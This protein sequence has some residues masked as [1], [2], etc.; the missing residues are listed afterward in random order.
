M[1]YRYKYGNDV[2]FVHV[3]DDIYMQ[4]TVTIRGDIRHAG[5]AG[6]E[7]VICE[8]ENGK[9]FMCHESKIYLDDWIRTSMKE[10]KERIERKELVTSADLCQAILS[11]G[12]D[13]V[14]FIV[15]LNTVCGLGFFLNG[16]KFKN[17]VCKIEERDN[18]EVKENYKLTVVPVKPDETVASSRDFYTDDMLSLIKSGH[19]QI[20]A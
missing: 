10:L 7:S 11:D 15:P 9:F 20:V 17:T 4:P 8:D 14:R 3:W 13:N 5:Y 1:V 2:I 6:Y 16:D 12:V 18:R 19:I